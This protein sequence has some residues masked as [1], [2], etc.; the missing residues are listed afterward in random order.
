MKF[1]YREFLEEWKNFKLSN[2][3]LTY[4]HLENNLTKAWTLIF[5]NMTLHTNYPTIIKIARIG[6]VI[7]VST[8]DCERGFS[9]LSI[10]K[11]RRRNK[12]NASLPHA[13]RLAIGKKE[14]DNSFDNSGD[15]EFYNFSSV[16]WNKHCSI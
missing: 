7:P 8:A 14:I 4:I 3:Q 9:Q 15:S 6:W 16:Q 12:L 5:E 1:R 11:N 13:L 2:I 10:L